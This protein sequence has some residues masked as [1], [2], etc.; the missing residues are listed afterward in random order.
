[1]HCQEPGS[2]SKALDFASLGQALCH[3][4]AWWCETSRALLWSK[5]APRA[6]E[7]NSSLRLTAAVPPAL[8][9]ATLSVSQAGGYKMPRLL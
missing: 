5:F 8:R 4:G 7:L 2:V 9:E 6:A 3:G 1:M